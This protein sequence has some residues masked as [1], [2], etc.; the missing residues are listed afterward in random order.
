MAPGQ[1][2]DGVAEPSLPGTQPLAGPG[3]GEQVGLRPGGRKE[4]VRGEGVTPGQVCLV[5]P[6]LSTA[7]PQPQPQPLPLSGPQ[8]PQL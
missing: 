2:G 4:A 8:H 1:R 5:R 7:Q 6:R 3:P